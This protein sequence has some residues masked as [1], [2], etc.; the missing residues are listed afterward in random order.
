MNTAPKRGR[1]RP[2]KGTGKSSAAKTDQRKV[3]PNVYERKESFLVRIHRTDHVTGVT[4]RINQTF[5]FDASAPAS[6]KTSRSAVLAMAKAFAAETIKGITLGQGPATKRAADDETLGRW[7]VRYCQDKVI[8]AGATGNGR[9]IRYQEGESKRLVAMKELAPDLFNR[10][11]MSLER[12]DFLGTNPE[13]LLQILTRATKDDQ[14]TPRFKPATIRRNLAKLSAMWTH[15][16]SHWGSRLKD[17]PLLNIR[18]KGADAQ[19]TRVLSPA[20]WS[21]VVS[22]LSQCS[23]G[24]KA[25]MVFVLT[26]ACR[27]G[28][29][30]D[31]L[32]SDLTILD[33]VTMATF[34]NTKDPKG[35]VRQRTVPVF[36]EA[37]QAIKDYLLTPEERAMTPFQWP[38]R[39]DTPVFGIKRDTLT[40]A[41]GRARQR[42]GLIDVRLHDLRHTS[43]TKMAKTEPSVL[44]LSAISGHKDIRMLQRYV[45]EQPSDLAQ[46][47]KDQGFVKAKTKG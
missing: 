17:N 22:G 47:A 1:G 16:V 5:P 42:Q 19:R 37:V 11:V 3:A 21:N 28:E 10:P 25:A 34:R 14:K 18:M 12:G 46:W 40:Q 13:S 24:T 7:V 2:P 43:L 33:G 44:R 41:F 29:A 15:A 23:P 35:R 8:E 30:I 45:N 26:T 4:H 6:H 32:W 31:L 38:K 9:K 36:D 39:G 27:R 20:E